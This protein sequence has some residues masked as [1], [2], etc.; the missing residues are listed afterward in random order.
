MRPTDRGVRE[1][2][3]KIPKLSLQFPTSGDTN[4]YTA[5]KSEKFRQPRQETPRIAQNGNFSS[6]RG[7]GLLQHIEVYSARLEVPWQPAATARRLRG[8]PQRL[9]A[10]VQDILE[11]FKFRNQLRTLSKAD[12]IGTLI[13]KILDTDLDLSPMGYS[14]LSVKYKQ[15]AIDELPSFK[16]EMESQQIFTNVDEAKVA[17]LRK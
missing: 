2:K 1:E 15:K 9:L 11:N 6:S 10:N 7:S 3:A 8:L 5:R 13:N 12:A 17:V 14:H 16:A 4:G